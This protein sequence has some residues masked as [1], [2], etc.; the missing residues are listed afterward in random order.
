MPT[1]P[2]RGP[3]PSDG[4]VVV[5]LGLAA[6]AWALLVVGS[7]VGSETLVAHHE[8]V[9]GE[10]P[11][12][13]GVAAFVPAW[14]VMV[15][16]MMLPSTLPVVGAYGRLTR[17]RPHHRRSLGAFLGAYLVVWLAFGLVALAGDVGLHALAHRW[18]WLEHHPSVV[19]AGVFAVA[20]VV[21]LLPVTRRCLGEC[22][23]P[24]RLVTRGGG[25]GAG[26][27]RVGVHHGVACLGA[28]WALMLLMFAVGLHHLAW[29]VLLTG[30]LVA[31]KVLPGGL[32][33]VPVIGAVLLGAA[34]VVAAT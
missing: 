25:A 3:G 12:L 24:A 20:G 19:T 9:E 33:L 32:R 21:Q 4:A 18:A 1:A 30:V 5:T 17:D 27:W 10:R 7:V 14:S 16:A 31:E 34:V 26:A 2:T 11:L 23:D 15:G 28:T 22:R 8:V 6:A 13:V 29:V